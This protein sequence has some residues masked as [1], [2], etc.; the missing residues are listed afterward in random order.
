[1]VESLEVSE[2]TGQIGAEQSAVFHAG[3]EGICR[4]LGWGGFG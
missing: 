3:V 4:K 1:M 2:L